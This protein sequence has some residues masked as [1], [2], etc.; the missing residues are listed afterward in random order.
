MKKS[1]VVF[2][3]VCCLFFMLFGYGFNRHA[4]KKMDSPANK[5]FAVVELF[6]SEGCSSCPPA[7][8]AVAALA[9]EYPANVYV[10]GFHVDYWN[11][12]GWTDEFSSGT[13]TSRQQRYAE[14]LKINSIYTPQAIVNGAIEF[15][16]S[17]KKRLYAAVKNGLEKNENTM[18]EV[19]AKSTGGKTITVQY[20][21]GTDS[22][23]VLQLA[24][25]QS[26]AT[27]AIKRGENKGMLLHHVNVV[28]AFKTVDANGGTAS[29]VLPEGLAPGDCRLIAYLQNKTDLHISG[30]NVCNIR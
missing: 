14:V 30:A 15:T 6:T 23:N 7:D 16:G 25:V 27:S 8:E 2:P 19:S 29:M 13:N 3:F 18:I 4:E 11:Y 26:V 9:K 20:K 12:L 22:K 28:R 21:T 5:G 17:D 1:L 24:I 10:L